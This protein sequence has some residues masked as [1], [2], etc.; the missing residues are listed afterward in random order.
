MINS[1][2]IIKQ[3]NTLTQKCISVG[4]CSD[5]EFPSISKK[6]NQ[7]EEVSISKLDL[8]P[9]LKNIRY[10]EMYD[11]LKTNRSFNLQMIDGALITMVYRFQKGE[12]LQHRLSFFPAPNLL[13]FQNEPEI[14]SYEDI[15]ADI[16][17]NRIVTVPLRFDYDIRS[18]VAVDDEHPIS[19]LTIGQYKNCRVAVSS[20]VLPYDFI[21]FILKNFYN[22]A[23]KKYH[24]LIPESKKYFERTITDLESKSIF[25][26]VPTK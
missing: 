3:I 15:Y 24:D 12:L 17:D 13:E 22:T 10:A 5:Q 11:V 20:A 23:Y 8:S 21:K 14:Y 4:L 2:D 19:H 7:I 26:S 9:S 6:N 25:I 18:D 1:S 16:L